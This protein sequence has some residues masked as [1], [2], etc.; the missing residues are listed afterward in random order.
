[1]H[2]ARLL[3]FVRIRAIQ[4]CVQGDAPCITIRPAVHTRLP[5]VLVSTCVCGGGA[6]ASPSA[7]P[8]L[9]VAM[10]MG[11]PLSPPC[12]Q[13]PCSGLRASWEASSLST[14]NATPP[15]AKSVVH[16]ARQSIAGLPRK[17]G[18]LTCCATNTHQV[19][20]E[21]GPHRKLPGPSGR[22]RQHHPARRARGARQSK[23][24]A[25][26][27]R[28]PGVVADCAPSSSGRMLPAPAPLRRLPQPAARRPLVR[29]ARQQQQASQPCRKRTLCCAAPEGEAPVTVSGVPE[30]GCG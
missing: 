5:N 1:M 12:G 4:P 30:V 28:C 11:K 20:G 9:L 2:I 18:K 3:A 16:L 29:P 23:P 6:H 22:A 24:A 17:L 10:H 15:A 8:G 14:C 21:H 7:R 25:Q 19:R 26:R 27:M 13:N